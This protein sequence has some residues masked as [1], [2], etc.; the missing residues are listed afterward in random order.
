[1]EQGT[2]QHRGELLESIIRK[3]PYSISTVARKLG[4]SRT[5]LYNKFKEC[6]LDYDFILTVSDLLHHDIKVEIPE[7]DTRV[8][9]SVEQQIYQRR[10]REKQYLALLERYR[11]IFAFLTKVTYQYGLD[12]VG[13]Q[14]DK[15][16]E[17]S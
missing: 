14:M 11:R 7:L 12:H 9:F 8:T 1:M 16:S 6:S 5:T 4:I 10:I 2:E 3:S 13:R 15:L 17:M